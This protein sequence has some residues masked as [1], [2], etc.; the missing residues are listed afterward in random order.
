M[1]TRSNFL[2]FSVNIRTI[3]MLHFPVY[4]FQKDI[5][6]SRENLIEKCKLLLKFYE[7]CRII[8]GK[9]GTIETI[10]IQLQWIYKK[11][12]RKTPESLAQGLLTYF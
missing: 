7:R 12:A 4:V 5:P 8:D 2:I 1:E 6:I 10:F 3:G 9:F 11:Q